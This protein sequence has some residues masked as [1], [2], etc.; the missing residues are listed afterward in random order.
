[1]GITNGDFETGDTTG[2]TID[3]AGGDV[4]DT[5][6]A[7]A[8]AGAKKTGSYGLQMQTIET[9]ES[10]CYSYSYVSQNIGGVA[11]GQKIQFWY[12]VAAGVKDASHTWSILIE[13]IDELYDSEVIVDLDSP[14]SPGWNYVDHTVVKELT[15]DVTLCFYMEMG[16][17]G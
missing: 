12:N 14:P 3:A 6:T 15:G 13:L 10:G 7:A 5:G 8:A 2:W 9:H 1:M 4:G 11:A 17:L 16:D